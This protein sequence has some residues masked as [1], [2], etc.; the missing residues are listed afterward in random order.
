MARSYV[1]CGGLFGD[2]ECD[3]VI[4]G[5]EEHLVEAV[6]LHAVT[7][8]RQAYSLEVRELVRDALSQQPPM[9]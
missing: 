3:L 6:M 9:S 2:G 1:D 8:H 5:S 4:S 7:A